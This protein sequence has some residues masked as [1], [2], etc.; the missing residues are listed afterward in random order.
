MKAYWGNGSIAPCI[1]DLG[2]TWGW[3]VS[4]TLRPLFPGERA[5]VTHWIGGW[6]GSRAILDVVVRRKIPR[7]RRE[8]NPRTPI[9]QPIAQRY[10][11]WA[12]TG[13][14]QIPTWIITEKKQHM[15]KG[16]K[17]TFKHF[18]AIICPSQWSNGLSYILS[19]AARKLGSWIRISLEAQMCVRIFL[20]CVVLSV[21]R[22]LAS[23]RSPIQGVLPTVQIDS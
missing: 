1:I 7:P 3:V 23:G 18:I 8:S 2:T 21:I 19:S 12:I 14:S 13:F 6:V 4:F 11:D 22:S 20:S 9:F 16:L 5:P 17:K 10:T 15:E